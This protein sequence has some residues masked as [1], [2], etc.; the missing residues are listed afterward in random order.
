LPKKPEYH[1]SICNIN[2]Q[3]SSKTYLTCS[4]DVSRGHDVSA[5]RVAGLDPE[6]EAEVFRSMKKKMIATA[7]VNELAMRT[8][9]VRRLTAKET[10]PVS[11][12]WHHFKFFLFAEQFNWNFIEAFSKY[13][14][15]IENSLQSTN[16]L[17]V[18]TL[19]F[20]VWT[21]ITK[22][23]KGKLVLELWKTCYIHFNYL[24]LYT[25]RANCFKYKNPKYFWPRFN[26]FAFDL[27]VIIARSSFPFPTS[28]SMNKFW[29]LNKFT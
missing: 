27:S 1:N 11:K 9:L 4:L 21:Q 29:L 5:D 8:Q 6:G 25:L 2:F 26:F 23:R 19:A 18:C 22:A 16:S 17:N 15:F 14:L 28:T 10:H 7:N 24:A 13:F 12:I 20:E 3:T